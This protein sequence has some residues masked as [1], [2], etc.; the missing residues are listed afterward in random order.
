MKQFID[1]FSVYLKTVKRT[2]DNTISSY[3]SDLG[4]M[5]EYMQQRGITYIQGVDEDKLVSYIA[6]LRDNNYRAASVS[7]NITSLKAFFRFLVDNG[8][9]ADNPAEKLK[10]PKLDKQDPRVLSTFEIDSLLGQKFGD[11]PSGKRDRAILELMYATGLKVSETIELRLDNIDMSIGCLRM[12]DNR[13]IPYGQKAKEALSDYLL[14]G[15]SSLANTETDI[16]FTNYSGEPMSRQGLWKLIKK[17]IKK[18]GIDTD[19]TPNALRNSFGVHLIENGANASA[20]Q[21]MMGYAGANSL[22]RYIKKGR[23]SKDP[24]EWARIRN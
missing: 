24:Y 13:L 2:S 15:R 1:E 11:S 22:T 5:A 10:G 16:V 4:K 19:I 9:I 3:A 14:D 6:H 18:A 12:G 21:E 20:V 7:R 8:N 23:Q 17:Y